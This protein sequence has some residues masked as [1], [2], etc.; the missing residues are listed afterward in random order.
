MDTEKPI[1]ILYV[2]DMQVEAEI[3]LRE[4]KKAG[5]QVSY[6]IVDTREAFL[7]ALE[8][9]KPDV[10]ISDYSMPY[11]DGMQALKISIERDPFLPFIMITGPTNEDTAVACMKAGATDYLIKGH[12]SR[13]PFA[14]KEAIES[15][16]ALKEKEKAISQLKESEERHRSIF[17]NN[18]SVMLMIDPVTSEIVDANP[19]ACSFYGWS[20]EQLTS[21]KI[22]EINILPQEEILQKMNTVIDNKAF[23]YYFRHRLAS[24]EI[25]D[26]EV[27]CSAIKF[28]EKAILFSIVNDVTDRKKAEAALIAAKEEAEA[29]NEAKSRFVANISHELR[30]PMNGIMGFSGLLASTALDG[31]QAEYNDMIK[32]SSEHLLE[33]INDILDFSK[34][35]AKKLRLENTVFDLNAAIN[36][37]IKIVEKQ[38]YKKGLQIYSMF[39]SEVNYK[40]SGDHLRVKQ[41]LLN[42]LSNAIK[43]TPDGKITV[44]LDQAQKNENKVLISISVV[45]TGIGIP[46]ERIDE[47]F[48]MFHQLENS[49]T[50]RFGGSG[51]GLSIVKGIVEMMEG[52]ISVTSEVGKGSCFKVLLPF[53]IA[54]GQQDLKRQYV[55]DKN[56]SRNAGRKLKVLL[57]EDD[58]MSVVLI[59]KMLSGL[60]W[61]LK[62]AASGVEAVNF[63]ESG[64]FDVIIMDGQMPDMDGFEAARKIREIEKNRGV[65]VPIIALSAYAMSDD[66][67]KFLASGMDDYISKP[68]HNNNILV[69]TIIK[70]VDAEKKD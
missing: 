35:E 41:I 52:E 50:G 18:H 36:D 63:Y 17:Y 13:L 20:H 49:D 4:I 12:I 2:E 19:A 15:K 33:V 8:E 21:M 47:T 39:A 53:E 34:I 43:F 11:F 29:A 24:G 64:E 31:E 9:F 37:C 14:I 60:G 61:E 54:S 5:I 58:M 55:N 10:V 68:M 62:I 48:Q 46:A 27:N 45:D 38:A 44:I 28:G 6:L 30:T 1:K 59:K 57:A 69:D 51:L 40:V 16:K 42:L 67:S 22:N 56:N 32:I 65:R 3:A 26:V 25:R 66:R 70:W 23:H 7:T